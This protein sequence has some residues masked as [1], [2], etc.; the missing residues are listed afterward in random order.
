MERL[1]F[2]PSPVGRALRGGRTGMV[3]VCFQA[4][5]SP[6]VARRLAVLQRVLRAA[7]LR[8][9]FELTD[10]DPAIELEVVRHFVAMRLDG[11]VLV[12]G[13]TAQN[14]EAIASMLAS[15][16][17]PAVLVDPVREYTLPSVGV[18]RGAGMRL[19]LEH[20][21]GL[22]HERFALL[23]IDE[24]TAYGGARWRGLR[25]L[26]GVRRLSVKRQFVTLAEVEPGG[27]DFAY[28]RRL[29]DRFLGLERRPTAIVAL[30][31]QVAVGAMTRLQQAG[32]DVP[33]E[34]SV[35]GFDNLD[36]G[37]HVNPRLTTVD[38]RVEE[39]M[40]GV[41]ARLMG[42]VSGGVSILEPRLVK[43]ES[44][45]PVGGG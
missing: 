29:A 16:R 14:E 34:V 9:L 10:G 15:H 7:G 22:G 31:D 18:D 27:L 21:L 24:G 3:G 32:L 45:G 23:G 6:I 28:G 39:L 19:A 26:A 41:V 12:G 44:S 42:G 40:Q 11:L 13:A 38:Q 5:G 2:V 20:L 17:T 35:V 36:V 4:L 30:N 1:G 37:A 25:E 43:G 33:T 8:A